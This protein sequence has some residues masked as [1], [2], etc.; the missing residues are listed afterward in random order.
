MIWIYSTCMHLAQECQILALKQVIHE[1][2]FV[3]VVVAFFPLVQ[4]SIQEEYT[5]A[6]FSKSKSLIAR[7]NFQ[8]HGGMISFYEPHCIHS[9][10]ASRA[11]YLEE[12]SK[13]IGRYYELNRLQ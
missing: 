1:V 5:G 10:R 4:I 9:W 3:F 12:S 2:I 6:Y 13:N 7:L 8:Y 11:N